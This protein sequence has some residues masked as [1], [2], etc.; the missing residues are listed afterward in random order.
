MKTVRTHQN[1]RGRGVFALILALVLLLAA[2]ADGGG[3]GGG[4]DNAG[5]EGAD[6]AGADGGETSEPGGSNETADEGDSGKDAAQTYKIVSYLDFSGPFASRGEP[7]E[8]MQR[9]LVDWFNDTRSKELGIELEYESFDTAYDTQQTLDVHSRAIQD[10]NVVGIVTFGS[11]NVIA[12]QEQLPNDGIPAVHG[13]PS[14]TLMTPGTWVFTPLG[15]YADYFTTALKWASENSEDDDPLRAAYVTFDGSSGRDWA[16]GLKANLDGLDVELVLEEYIPPTASDVGTNA[17]RIVEAD[18]DVAIL[19]TTD[20]L[21][22]LVLDALDARGF[23]MTKVIHS[24]HEGLGLLQQLGVD[25]SLIEGTHEVTTIDYTN[26]DSEAFQIYS[27]RKDE[28]ETRWSADT[29]LHVPSMLTLLQAIEGAANEV[30]A[31]SLTGQ[32]VYD[33]LAGGEFDGFGLIESIR[34]DSEDPTKGATSAVIL[35]YADGSIVRATDDFIPL[36]GR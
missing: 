13:G 10:D 20:Q 25:D 33:Q 12:L 7:V 15:D 1:R 21:Q 14:Y 3:S 27:E 4:A 5:G 34:F 35:E 28:F 8:G 11:P 6:N 18:P 23:D 22:P 32:A 29:L 9:L 36:I 17:D 30:G 16:E 2:C 19:A 31:D 26:E 24:Q